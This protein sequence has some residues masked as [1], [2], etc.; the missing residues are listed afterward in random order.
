MAERRC[1]F[2]GGYGGAVVV[3]TLC[4]LSRIGAHVAE[5]QPVYKWTDDKGVVHFS[6][7]PPPTG[8]DYQLRALPPPPVGGEE[9]AGETGAA[10]PQP[11]TSAADSGPATIEITE[12]KEDPVGESAHEYRG[13]VKNVGGRK[14]TDVAV[15]LKV[16]ETNQGAECLDEQIPVQ[17]SVLGPGETGTYSAQ[18][19]NPCYFGP[20][21]AVLRP[22]WR[23]D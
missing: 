10:A 15:L 14:A 7:E 6:D 23:E 4:F 18:F 3:L 16:T 8:V 20:T 2:S 5:A 21:S 19:S 11:T 12:Q 1:G 9:P 17:P 13:E 22:D